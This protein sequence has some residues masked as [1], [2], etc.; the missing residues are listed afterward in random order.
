MSEEVTYATLQF[1]SPSKSKKLQESGSLKRTV[2]E[3]E[4]DGV[5]ENRPEAA[6]STTEVA[7]STAM[8]GHSSP[9]KMWGLVAFIVLLL[10]LAVMAGM[11]TLILIDYQKLFFS[12][13]TAYDKQQSII[14]QLERNITLYLDMY[15][16]ISSEHIFFKNMLENALKELKKCTPKYIKSLQQKDNDLRCCSCSKACKC[17]KESKSNSSSPRCDSEIFGNGTQALKLMEEK[18][19]FISVKKIHENRR[20]L[21]T[22]L[23]TLGF[24]TF[25]NVSSAETLKY[26][27]FNGNET[28]GK[29]NDSSS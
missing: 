4:L 9:W 19:C 5:A 2:P 24:G 26:E 3:L 8:N 12:N 29:S 16:N 21:K 22:L 17:Q 13:G 14:E 20:V 27:V 25:L 7:E 10:N 1:P 18:L 15:K 23:I 11:G 6:E 28:I